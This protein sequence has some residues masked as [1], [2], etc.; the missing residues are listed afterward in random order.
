MTHAELEAGKQHN[1]LALGAEY[2]DIDI[3]IEIPPK[4]H[5]GSQAPGITRD[6]SKEGSF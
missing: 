6:N 2:K 1:T 3:T 4:E 5:W